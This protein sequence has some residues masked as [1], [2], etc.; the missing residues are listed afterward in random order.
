MKLFQLLFLAFSIAFIFSC[1]KDKKADYTELVEVFDYSKDAVFDTLNVPQHLRNIVKQIS[2]NNV[3][4]TESI[5]KGVNKPANFANFE[6][7]SK[8]ASDNELLSLVNNK[9]KTVAVY[10]AIGLLDRK[11]ELLNKIFLSFLNS[12]TKI[13]TENSCIFGDQNPAK[14]LYHAYN[15]SLNAKDAR[16]DPMLQKLDSII[17]FNPNSPENLLQEALRYKIYPKN[18]RKRIEDLAFQNHEISAI[19]YL[20]HWHKGDYSRILQKEF[21]SM[22][23]ND[24]FAYSKK[25]ILSELLSFK[26]PDNKEFILDYLKKDT[27]LNDEYEIIWQL[28][29]NGIFDGEYP[30]KKGY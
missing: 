22:I 4:Q 27:L 16:T 7:L 21:I 2:E 26:N 20:S 24:S 9:N 14:P 19:N 18:F 6:E 5:G 17:I 15:R 30:R 28:N 13:Y 25:K 23:K 3:Y 29:D 8:I 1:K 12:K 11:P 10:A